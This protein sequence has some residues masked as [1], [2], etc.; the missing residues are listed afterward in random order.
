[1]ARSALVDYSGEV[2]VLRDWTGDHLALVESFSALVLIE[3][4][5]GRTV[6]M[7][8]HKFKNRLV[9]IATPDELEKGEPCAR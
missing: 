7:S 8:R 3:L 2:V 1:M 9:R 4:V 5:D 6:A